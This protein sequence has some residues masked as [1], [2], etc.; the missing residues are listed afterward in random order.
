MYLPGDYR[1]SAT[2]SVADL[3]PYE[4]D[5]YLYDLRS[6]PIKQGEDDENQPVMSQTSPPSQG[7][8]SNQVLVHGQSHVLQA[9][10][11]FVAGLIL[12]HVPGF[13][14]VIFYTK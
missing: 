13:V 6:N 8:S 9:Q 3:S 5:D 7:S 11:E 1:V 4:E 12:A 2:F 14:F 10:F